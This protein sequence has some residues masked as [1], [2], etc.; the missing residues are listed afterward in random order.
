MLSPLLHSFMA[1]VETGSITNAAETLDVAKSA[2]SQNLKRL[3][4]QLGVKLAARTTRRLS[5]TPAGEHYYRRCREILI[6]SEQAKTEMETYGRVPS[7]PFT[8]TAPHALV[9]PIIAPAMVDMKRRFPGLEPSV[10]AED[11]RLD[12]VAEGIDL[13]ISVGYLPHSSLRARRIGA[14]RDILCAAP[15]LMAD[16]PATDDPAFADWAQALP[17]IAHMR[18]A[19]T[20]EHSLPLGGGDADGE[21]EMRLTFQSTF[22]CNTLEAMAAFARKGLG[23]ALLP[24]IGIVDDLRAERLIPL[25]GALAPDP[26]PIFAVHAYDALPPKSVQETIHAVG[27]ALRIALPHAGA[28]LDQTAD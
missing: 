15:E 26:T 8:I 27:R 23:V 14:L 3:E 5:L 22:R 11:K 9:A 28:G 6:L 20:V 12:L 17:Y 16:A 10:I 18:E 24:D 2:V 7:G 21:G 4:R 13:S 25:C 19:S 1:I